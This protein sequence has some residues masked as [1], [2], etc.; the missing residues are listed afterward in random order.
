MVETKKKRH[1]IKED[2][3]VGGVILIEI[4]VDYE[5]DK[6]TTTMCWVVLIQGHTTYHETQE[7]DLSF[8]I[9]INK[10]KDLN[11]KLFRF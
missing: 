10:M 5:V 9:C 8:Q 6:G 4:R 3:G 7:I 2:G 1:R 11:L